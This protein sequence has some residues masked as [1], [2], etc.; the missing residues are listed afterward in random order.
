GLVSKVEAIV[1]PMIIGGER[2]RTPVEGEGFSRIGDALRLS[3]VSVGRLGEDVHVTGYT[4]TS[5]GGVE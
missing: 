2:A 4:P 3:R 5:R 1:A